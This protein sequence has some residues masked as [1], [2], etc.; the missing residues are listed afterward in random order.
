MQQQGVSSYGMVWYGCWC[1]SHF[2]EKKDQA[3]Q[4]A[5]EA[6]QMGWLVRTL[7][8]GLAAA[9]SKGSL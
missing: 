2:D 4:L 5:Q 7:T 6:V 8:T 9:R 3:H 1:P